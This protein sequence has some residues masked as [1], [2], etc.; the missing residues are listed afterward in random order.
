MSAERD[1]YFFRKGM[2]HAR[3]LSDPTH[4]P[5]E[6]YG[7]DLSEVSKDAPPL[8]VWSSEPPTEPGWYW[9]RDKEGLCVIECENFVRMNG[10]EELG[11]FTPHDDD[12]LQ[13]TPESVASFSGPWSGPIPEPAEAEEQC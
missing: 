12:P 6:V 2:E 1:S 5:V 10:D 8:F 11:V 3:T 4:E 9:S 13:L 7:E